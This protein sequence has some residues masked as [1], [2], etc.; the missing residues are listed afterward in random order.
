[1]ADNLI[2]LLE[3]RV[4]G[5]AEDE[6]DIHQLLQSLVRQHLEEVLD[7]KELPLPD[8]PLG[9]ETCQLMARRVGEGLRQDG[10]V[11]AA[12]L[13]QAVLPL[14]KTSIE[15]DVEHIND[16]LQ[17]QAALVKHDFSPLL[18]Q[19]RESN[20]GS[21]PTVGIPSW[22]TGYSGL[23]HAEWD[24]GN[25]QALPQF[26]ISFEGGLIKTDLDVVGKI[27]KIH[28][29][30]TE[31]S[32]EVTGV[33]W[34]IGVL[35]S[36]NGVDAGIRN[37]SARELVDGLNRI[38][39]F[40]SLHTKCAQLLAGVVYTLEGRQ[41]QDN[42]FKSKVEKCLAEYFAAP[43]MSSQRQYVAQKLT[44]LLK[45]D[46]HIMR[47]RSAEITRLTTSRHIARSGRQRGAV[48]GEP[49]CEVRCLGLEIQYIEFLVSHTPEP[50]RM[51]W[52]WS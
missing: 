26:I 38:F 35:G 7:T 42:R 48:N 41:S 36:L 32:G 8:E 45:Y 10:D 51:A 30:D 12:E 39:P 5:I 13:L 16:F 34:A 1:M 37:L 40:D 27:E 23:D 22:V 29:L 49:I 21:N 14:S 17:R 4:P 28:Y 3:S 11:L 24:L 50:R 6:A 43:S 31:D 47:V 33:E 52:A 19:P 15:D 25:Q 2:N 9:L 44:R 46:T 20:Q 18:L